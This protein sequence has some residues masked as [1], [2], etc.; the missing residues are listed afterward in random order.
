MAMTKAERAQVETLLTEAALRRTSRVDPDVPPPSK[1][2]PFGILTS[3]FILSGAESNTPTV[4]V[5]CSSSVYHARGRTDKTT[6][7]NAVSLYSTRL[8]ALRGLRYAVESRCASLLRH[9]DCQIEEELAK[10]GNTP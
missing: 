10:E 7:Q 1:G 2:T 4:D 6:T 9:V 8:L 3:G 5:G